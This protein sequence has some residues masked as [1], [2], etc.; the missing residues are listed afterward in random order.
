MEACVYITTGGGGAWELNSV[1]V[2]ATIRLG[3]RSKVCG[4]G[5]WGEG[6]EKDGT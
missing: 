5:K 1:F 6:L 2:G 3:C 4:V